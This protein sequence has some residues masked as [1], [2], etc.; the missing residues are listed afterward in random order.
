MAAT[1]TGK[2]RRD[3]SA[4]ADCAFVELD[5]RFWQHAEMYHRKPDGNVTNCPN[6]FGP[7]MGGRSTQDT[8]DWE[9]WIESGDKPL[10]RKLVITYKQ[11]PGSP[12]FVA[13]IRNWKLSPTFKPGFFEFKPPAKAEQI[14]MLPV[15][16]GAT[17][18]KTKT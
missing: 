13:T 15:S 11:Q 17:E 5:G 6:D 1:R 18:A 8:I 12:R 14:E 2:Y 7:K 16:L 3:K 10:P 9:T 4:S